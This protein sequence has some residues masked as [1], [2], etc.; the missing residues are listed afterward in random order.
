MESCKSHQ[1]ACRNII[2]FFV[3]NGGIESSYAQFGRVVVKYYCFTNL[4]L[5]DGRHSTVCNH[6]ALC[7][8]YGKVKALVKESPTTFYSTIK[9]SKDLPSTQH[10]TKEEALYQI[11]IKKYPVTF[12]NECL[13]VSQSHLQDLK[14]LVPTEKSCFNCNCPLNNPQVLTRSCVIYDLGRAYKGVSLYYKQCSRCSMN[15]YYKEFMDGI[16]V[17][18]TI[19][20]LT[21]RFC[22]LKCHG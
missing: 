20:C 19:S 3:W 8:M 13:N 9:S 17:A 11:K 6:I 18:D 22:L 2:C 12:R 15:Y 4:F 7:K 10:L 14:H 5:C 16:H 1:F 21:L